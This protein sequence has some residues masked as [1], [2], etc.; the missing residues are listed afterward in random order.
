MTQYHRHTNAN[1]RLLSPAPLIFLG[2]NDSSSLT[3]LMKSKMQNIKNDI[4]EQGGERCSRDL[5]GKF[6]TRDSTVM[7]EAVG[8]WRR[9]HDGT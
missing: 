8:E 5:A 7:K 3:R 6:S 2:R 4:L 9:E 1:N